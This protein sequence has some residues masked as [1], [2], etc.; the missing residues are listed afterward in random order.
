MCNAVD[1]EQIPDTGKCSDDSKEL[2]NVNSI[3]ESPICGFADIVMGRKI[4]STLSDVEKY[5]YLTKHYC[6]TDESLLFQKR[7]QQG[8]ET[9]I[10][11]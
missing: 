2:H 8:G 4:L 7:V 1:D 10:L 3:P 5:Q 11:T 6:P 9:K